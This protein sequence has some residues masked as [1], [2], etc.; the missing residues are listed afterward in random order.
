M[1]KPKPTRQPPSAWR[2]F[3]VATL[4]LAVLVAAFNFEIVFLG[5][6]LVPVG[7]AG[8]MGAVGAYPA[9]RVPSDEFRLDPGASEWQIVPWTRQA[10]AEY[11]REEIPLWNPHQGFGAPLLANAQSGVFDLWRL[12]LFGLRGALVWDAYDLARTLL[13][14]LAAYEFARSIG[15]VQTARF[16]L[17]ISYI[18]S[19]HFILFSN[20]VWIEAYY[21][22]P[23][24]L[25]ATEILIAGHAR[26]AFGITVASV[27]SVILVGMPEVALFVALGAG[28]Y[29]AYRLLLG[30]EHPLGWRKRLSSLG[31][32]VSAWILGLGLA[33]PLLL[34]FVEYLVNASLSRS[35]R[36]A[37]GISHADPRDLFIWIAPY[38]QGY[39][40]QTLDHW[41][42]GAYVGS[43]VLI[44]ATI[45]ALP[46]RSPVYR[47]VSPFA[48]ALAALLLAKTY[49]L[50]L[51]NEVGRLPIFDNVVSQKWS[52]P[53]TAFCLALLA[54]VGVH[55]LVVDPPRRRTILTLLVAFA[56][57]AMLVVGISSPGTLASAIAGHAGWLALMIG[58]WLAIGI[59]ALAPPRLSKFTVGSACCAIAWIELAVLAPH[60]VYPERTDPL[61]VPPFVRYIQDQSGAGPFRVFAVD[62]VLYPNFASALGLDDPRAIDALYPDRYLL[63]VRTFLADQV[64]DRYVG[65]SLGSSES[66]TRV[67]NNPWFD[68]AGVRYV[69]APVH[70]AHAPRAVASSASTNANK[71]PD[72]P[73]G[74]SGPAT[75]STTEPQYREVYHAE[76][77]VFEN[78]RALSRAFL[79]EDVRA[80]PDASAAIRTMQGKGNPL[81]TT[82]PPGVLSDA[83]RQWVADF[84]KAHGRPPS[85]QD[86]S[87]RAWSLAFVAQHGHPPTDDDWKRH[88]EDQ[89]R[90]DPS[91]TAVVE[92]VSP[93][94]IAQLGPTTGT[95]RVSEDGDQ[96]TVVDV[97]SSQPAFLVLTELY[98]PGWIATVDGTPTPIFPTDLAFR[99]V[100]V[101]AGGHVVRFAYRPQSF[102]EGVDVALGALAIS[103]TSLLLLGLKKGCPG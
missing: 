45:G 46:F 96:T 83:D 75:T 21:L 85:D 14:A 13:G 49:G 6:T 42:V 3:V 74:A 56:A 69:V 29:A 43:T 57:V 54:A 35:G 47:R 5:H 31:L 81:V 82:P 48:M 41:G 86:W 90:V 16:F 65:S 8:V 19:G 36:D 11:A 27:A 50:P 93:A 64:T 33:A 68:L 60:G 67:E 12:P 15:L 10:G 99:G 22:L 7:T 9:R 80:V 1:V 39:P 40:V 32:T 53:V 77:D 62:G 59:V 30:A 17:A 2:E 58:C 37:F 91:R 94:E 38:L 88:A 34:P 92:N 70:S 55:R 24:L 26:V 61:A 63:Y 87:D 23:I 98:F 25:L 89:L 52:A 97:Q 102:A 4:V 79:V 84:E 76:V 18:F 103:V 28:S 95:A 51:V 20:N 73:V 101:P 44:L 66:P 71:A 100:V 78:R 72:A